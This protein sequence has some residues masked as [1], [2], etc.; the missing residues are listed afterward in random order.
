MT[1]DKYAASPGTYEARKRFALD[2]F[3][4]NPNAKMGAVRAALRR[5]F[6]LAMDSYKLGEL[7][8]EA[9]AE[10]RLPPIG[11]KHKI[12]TVRNVLATARL[13]PQL[14]LVDEDDVATAKPPPV[15]QGVVA[16]EHTT[17]HK[18][19]AIRDLA[20]SIENLAR[21]EVV[22]DDNGGA[23]VRYTIREVRTHE[24]GNE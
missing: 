7:R 13:P 15:A 22:V 3:R 8:N 4:R 17:D 19:A 1:R 14:E 21:L 10:K 23:A 6:G 11:P 20:L 5:N 18:L 16:T 9:R 12:K 24:W 2:F